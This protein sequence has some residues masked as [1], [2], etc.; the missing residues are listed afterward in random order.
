MTNSIQLKR[1][2]STATPA[3]LL[4]GEPGFSFLSETLYIGGL[5]GATVIPIGGPGL[6]NNYA[7]L[8][9][10]VFTGDPTAPTPAS[11]DND[12]SI[13]T[14]AF[15][16]SQSLSDFQPPTGDI[17]WGGFKITGLADPT[18]PLDAANKQYVDTLA[19]GLTPKGS[20]RVASQLAIDLSAPGATIDGTTMAL[21]DRV[22]IKEGS[23]TNPG[24]SSID[25]GIY[26]VDTQTQ[27]L[28]QEGWKSYNEIEVGDIALTLNMSTGESEWQPILELAIFPKASYKALYMKG[29]SHSSI[30]TN[31]H[32]WPVLSRYSDN[33]SIKLSKE[34]NSSHSLIKAVPS[35]NQPNIK[36]YS[37]EVVELVAWFITEGNLRKNNN[38]SLNGSTRITQSHVVNKEHCLSIKQTLTTLYGDSSEKLGYKNPLPTWSVTLNNRNTVF[39]LNAAAS[40]ILLKLAPN[41]V[42]TFEFINS[43]TSEQLKLF[44]KTCINADGSKSKTSIGQFFQK[45]KEVLEAVELVAILAGYSTNCS[46]TKDCYTLT[47]S[48]NTTFNPVKNANRN[49]S[50]FE[51]KNHEDIFWCPRTSNT[52]WLAKREGTV[53]YT[54]NTWKGAAVPMVRASDFDTDDD[55]KAS[56]YT[57]VEEGTDDNIGFVLITNNPITVG[58][59][60]LEFTPFTG[61]GSIIAGDGLTQ[62]GNTFNIVSA[63]SGRIVVNANDIDLAVSGV[64]AGTYIGFTID[65]YGRTTSVTTPTTLAGY[66]ITDAQAGD[67]DLDALAALTTT[68]IA[69]RTGISTWDTRTITGTA[70]RV[71]VTNGDGVAG[72]PVVDIS[73]TYAGQASITTLGTVTTGTWNADV[74]GEEYGGT[75]LSSFLANAVFFANAGATAMEQDSDFTFNPVS[76]T[77]TLNGTLTGAII[78]GGTF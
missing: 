11:T 10:P 26:C 33:I 58:T 13:A 37:D 1:S 45:D 27:L 47:V 23:T 24:A 71:D 55:V 78:D 35:A 20:V 44:V 56:S 28:T 31:N 72:N 60:P 19:E 6:L 61:A 59:T 48:S 9:S 50:T 22:L 76:N 40:S 53:Y 16:K 15:V 54:G 18:N 39:N 4:E 3:S 65:A 42:P 2:N 69:V 36:I 25:N 8:N 34:L 66:G 67:P 12:T 57:F 52:T 38:G 74:I 30:T 14:T 73:A 7:L 41:K 63:D 75:G 49:S 77:L 62:S 29:K 32:R 43:M 68:G 46:K 51:F 64:V 70:S 17:A 21:D 5:G